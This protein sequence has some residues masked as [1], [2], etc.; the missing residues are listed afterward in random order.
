[1]IV[2]VFPSFE[3]GFFC[4]IALVPVPPDEWALDPLL[5]LDLPEACDKLLE[6]RFWAKFMP[7]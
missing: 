6:H 5:K 4:P 1:M 7:L 3:Y 2:F